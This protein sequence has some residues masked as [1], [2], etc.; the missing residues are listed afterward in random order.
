MKLT[1]TLKALIERP[2]IL[3]MPGA[4]DPISAKLVEQAGF[5]A[6]QVS[7]LAVAAS[8]LGMPDVS[9]LSLS[10][11]CDRTR[12]IVNASALPVM[13][14]GDTG[15]GN[16]VNVWYTVQAVEITGAAGINLEDQ[17][18]PKRCGHLD[19][20][21]VISCEEMVGKIQAAVDARRDPDFVINARTD[22]LAVEGLEATIA[23]ANAYFMAGASMVFVDGADDRDTISAL[24]DA[25]HGPLA[26]N[27]VEGGKTPDG[28]TFAELQ[29]RGV[30]RVSLPVS[31]LLSAIHGMQQALAQISHTGTTVADPKLF[32]DFTETH[33][34]L[35]ME[36]V[37]ELERRFMSPH[38]WADKYSINTAKRNL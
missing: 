4:Y 7:G 25:F 20:K 9:I 14:D 28:M 27:M 24:A 21:E 1:T 15:F 8:H 11:M 35:G 6:I 13:A 23:R 22:A 12:S 37:Y 33:T 16:A 38:H 2:E 19:G 32:A 36:H 5:E 34:L 10:D 29:H 3:I 31:T 30:A 18:M 17:V 26:V